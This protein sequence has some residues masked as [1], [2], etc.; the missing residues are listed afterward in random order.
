M[1]CHRIHNIQKHN[2][3]VSTN[4]L[5]MK[6]ISILNRFPVVLLLAFALISSPQTCEGLQIA[7]GATAVWTWYKSMLV[8]QPL[9]TKSLTSSC[10]MSVSDV[11]CQEVVSKANPVKERPLKLDSTRILHV[12]ITGALWSGPITHYWYIVLER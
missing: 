9:V 3:L 5:E 6:L 1:R 2:L 11:I 12:A 7:P 4:L 10:I 8:I